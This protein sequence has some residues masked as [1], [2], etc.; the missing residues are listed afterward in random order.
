MRFWKLSL[1]LVLA[2]GCATSQEVIRA[3]AAERAAFDLDCPAAQITSAPLGD[4]LRIGM[5]AQAPGVE[6]SVIGVKGCN[7]KAV[8]VVECVTGKCN[9]Q[10]NANTQ[11]TGEVSGTAA[12]DPK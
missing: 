4:T 2:A 5:T 8:Y 1:L 10:L 11:S 6:R 12:P 9:A 3:T 7:K